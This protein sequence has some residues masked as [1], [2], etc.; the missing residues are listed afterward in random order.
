MALTA[1]S[2]ISL[3]TRAPEFALPD[4]SGRIVS[5]HDFDGQNALI[6]AFWCNHCPFVKHIKAKFA[7]FAK[8][9]QAR[10]VAIVAINANDVVNYPQDR[11]E[12]MLE[13]A[14]E[15]GF[16]FDYL[17]DA[18]QQTAR[19]YHAACTPDIFLFDRDR[20]LVYHGQFDASRPNNNVPVDGRDL[21]S[22]TEALLAGRQPVAN[23]VP[24]IGCNIKWLDN[25][26]AQ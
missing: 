22:A 8:E 17:I 11:P 16:T 24:C 18:D 2:T 3:G 20:K 7:E 25:A 5:L 23:Q 26:P 10:N 6:V 13:D 21:R 15:F 14:A 1:S 4:A 19:A 9:F 12:K